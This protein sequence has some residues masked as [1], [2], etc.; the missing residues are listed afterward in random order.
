MTTLP[1]INNNLSYEQI[2]QMT[3]Q[4]M[5]SKSTSTL[6]VLKINR[7]FEDD[8]GNALPSGTFTVNTDVMPGA[9]QLSDIREVIE[10]EKVNCLFSDLNLIHQ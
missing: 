10:H 9:E 6:K 4:E 2:A 7:D 3:G 8:D 1:T 5:P